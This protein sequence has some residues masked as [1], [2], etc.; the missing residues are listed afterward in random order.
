MVTWSVRRLAGFA[1]VLAVL[2]CHAGTDPIAEQIT[3][4]D[5]AESLW[6]AA[7]IHHYSYEIGSASDWFAD[8][9]R[10]D[11][12]NDV[13]SSV[14]LLRGNA[15]AHSSGATVPE[16]F[17]SIRWSLANGSDVRAFYDGALGYPTHIDA[18]DPPGMADARWGANIGKFRLLPPAS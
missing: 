16:L 4:L 18:P 14:T 13:V 1:A 15:A 11:V 12:R 10:V 3:D 17:A 2:G 9:L 6:Q 7:G 8:S 5:R